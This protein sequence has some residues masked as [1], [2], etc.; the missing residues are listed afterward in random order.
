[1]ILYI[2]LPLTFVILIHAQSLMNL[3]NGTSLV[4][5]FIPSNS[6]ICKL[7]KVL[8]ITQMGNFE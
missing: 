2:N 7:S 1:M 4:L 5:E 3:A 8:Y 6:T